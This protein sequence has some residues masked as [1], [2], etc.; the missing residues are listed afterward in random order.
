MRRSTGPF[1]WGL[2]V[3]AAIALYWAWRM[4]RPVADDAEALLLDPETV[5]TIA[6]G[7]LLADPELR[8]HHLEVRSIAPGILD[9]SGIVDSEQAAARALAV[10]RASRGVRTV[11]NRVEVRSSADGARATVADG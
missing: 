11:L 6:A 8:Q 7:A 1:A 10:V 4:A 9:L 2:T 5:R 3:G